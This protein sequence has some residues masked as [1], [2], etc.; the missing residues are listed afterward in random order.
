MSAS[1]LRDIITILQD[2]RYTNN[3]IKTKNTNDEY[4]KHC[5]SEMQDISNSD[6]WRE[7]LISGTPGY[8]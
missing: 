5:C 2:N 1:L 3:T 8:H 4:V 7:Y 6:N